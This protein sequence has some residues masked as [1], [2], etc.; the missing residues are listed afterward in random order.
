MVTRMLNG[1]G[2]LLTLG[3]LPQRIA[4]GKIM[5]SLAK[6][7][8]PALSYAADTGSYAPDCPRC[9]LS[10]SPLTRGVPMSSL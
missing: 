5:S 8:R 9:R 3:H 7:W 6:G 4:T 2:C 1:S 10:E